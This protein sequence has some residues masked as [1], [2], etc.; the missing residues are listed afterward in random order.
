MPKHAA[1][2][3]AALLALAAC[4]GGSKSLSYAPSQPATAQEQAAADQAE[5]A[6]EAGRTFTPVAE[7]T[8]AAPGLADQ[9]AATLGGEPLP[10]ASTAGLDRA[11]S[12]LL[13]SL[14][15]AMP[16]QARQ[17]VGRT[18][19]PAGAPATAATLD[20]ACVTTTVS[21]G[22]GSVVWSGCVVHEVQTDPV[23]GDVTELTLR[24]DG[25]LDWSG[26]TGVTTWGI[27][28]TMVMDMTT[29][30]DTMAVSAT[31]GLSGAITNKDG[32]V[33]GSS[34]SNVRSTVSYMGF[35]ATAA[36]RTTMA[37]DL[38]YLADPFCIA[39]GTLTLE[40][41]WTK[42]P[43]GAD[44]ASYPDRGWRISWTGDGA[45]CGQVFVAHGS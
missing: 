11:T 19:A 4:G 17:A 15:A 12:A 40:Q 1:A 35:S 32:T 41:V 10:T 24:V 38:A 2:G 22:T 13:A 16:A 45:T 31:V 25:R 43:A 5:A 23:S 7:P 18:M 39:T 44:P 34:T 33:K 27:T 20:P 30:T 8:T 28:E 29:G 26:A 42:L 36:M 21:A 3:L 6:F 9:L 37:V 14:P